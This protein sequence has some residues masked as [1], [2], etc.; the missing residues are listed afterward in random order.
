[1]GQLLKI[2]DMQT[3]NYKRIMERKAYLEECIKTEKVVIHRGDKY[4][5][6]AVQ[7]VPS[8][9]FVKQLYFDGIL[10]DKYDQRH[11]SSKA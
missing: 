7:L 4:I 10:V 6:K 8:H 9:L 2:L 1:M 11:K 3:R 5:I